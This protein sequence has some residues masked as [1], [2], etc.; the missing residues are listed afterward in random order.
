VTARSTEGEAVTT[1]DASGRSLRGVLEAAEAA[2]PVEAV[3]AV[4]GELG[5]ALG[6]VRVSFLIADLAG[7]SLARLTVEAGEHPVDQTG[8]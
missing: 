5:R 7:R 4:T 6:A 1:A 2:S 8:T 3:E